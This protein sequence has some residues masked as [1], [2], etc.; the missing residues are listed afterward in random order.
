MPDLVTTTAVKV[1]ATLTEELARTR[2]AIEDIVEKVIMTEW[3]ST[4]KS[5]CMRP[6]G[7]WGWNGKR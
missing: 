1:T 7:S 4:W 6:A 5:L 2:A 3:L